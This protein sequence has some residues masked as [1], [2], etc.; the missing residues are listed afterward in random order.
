VAISGVS[1]AEAEFTGSSQA[2][3]TRFAREHVN[4]SALRD[5]FAWLSG[6]PDTEVSVEASTRALAG[7]V[8]WLLRGWPTRDPKRA[9]GRLS[10]LLDALEAAP[11][12]RGSVRR[13]L[14]TTLAQVDAMPLFESGLSNDRGIWEES[15]DR[16][17]RRFLPTLRDEGDLGALLT[18]WFADRRAASWLAELPAGEALRIQ[19]LLSATA[20]SRLRQ[21]LLDA[22]ALI[23]ARTS[24]L[25]LSREIRA[26]SPKA[27]LSESPFFRLP[28]VCDAL[29]D[30]SG[31][32]EACRA[33]ILASR[34][35]LGSVLTHLERFGVS[36]D[37]VYR[38]EV[39][40]KNLNRLTQLVALLDEPG[41]AK[42]Q[43]ATNLLHEIAL[44]R[45]NDRSLL[46]LAGTNIHLLARKVIE[47]AGHTGEH[48]ITISRAE[49]W[50]MLSSAAGGGFLTAF[51]CALK[52]VISWGHFP[53]FVEGFFASTNYA[54]SFLLIQLLG[55]TLATKQP[56]AIGA[57]LAH[58]LHG[59][60]TAPALG[61]L[62]TLIA[63]ICRSQ[64]IAV[65]GNVGMVIPAA[66][67]FH[68]GY[69]R[70]TGE[71]FLDLAAAEYTL[72]SFNPFETGT[73]YFAA[74]T[75]V[76]L[77]LSSLSAGWLENWSTYHRLPEAIAAR[78]PRWLMRWASQKFAH[79]IAGL[80]GNV[81]LGFLLGMMPVMGKF[82]GVPLEV[83]HVTL[84][85]GALTLAVCSLGPAALHHGLL[86]A[87]LGIFMILSLNFGVSFTLA[88]TVA[89]KA[90][91][92]EHAGRRL[93]PAL[94]ARFSR[95]P[96]EFFF[97]PKNPAPSQ[98]A[99]PH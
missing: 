13:L 5:L 21:G 41:E 59:S 32:I 14:A 26:R 39:I 95:T 90:R 64:F 60:T 44:A 84:S 50:K 4:R 99:P 10:A 83:R 69:E 19:S 71:V 98:T 40:D 25:G 61:E 11:T 80:G 79:H 68:V 81:S 38:I 6:L 94:I 88:L 17:A 73:V 42:A 2:F 57:A 76:F 49:Y 9:Q 45:I 53:L 31:S 16:L 8:R 87:V 89:L 24:A 75:G 7:G 55:F 56:S 78:S 23:A 62:V 67:A 37:V 51:T 82:L 34:I 3:C 36:V 77:W 30:G 1:D 54:C 91:G 92:V 29:L 27:G 70:V 63:R 20:A 86:E 18:A 48:Y 52:Y 72:H 85:T 74:L 97:P 35:A 47:R 46:D 22:I 33:Q 96:T 15:K 93:I 66:I 43:V 28:R 58:A 12:F 65:V